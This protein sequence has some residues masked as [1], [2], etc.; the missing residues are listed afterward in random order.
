VENRIQAA[1]DFDRA[2]IK[3]FWRKL[4]NWITGRSNDLLPFDEVRDKLPL[5]GQ[6]YIGLEQVPVESIV[7][8]LGR[9]RDFD[10][11]FLPRQSKTRE[12]WMSIDMAHY[13]Q[14]ILPPVELYKIGDVYFVKDGNHRVS[15]ARERGQLYMDAYIT[16]IDIPVSL[17]PDITVDELAIKSEYAEFLDKTKLDVL[18]PGANL[19]SRITGQG[20]RLL[21]HIDVHRWYLG[22]NSRREIPYSDAVTSWYDD[23]YTP[24]VDVFREQGLA[25]SFSKYS[26][27]DLYLW[28]M[29]YQAYL[30]EAYREEVSGEELPAVELDDIVREEAGV[31]FAEENPELPVRKLIRA[32]EKATWLDEM[33]LKQ[34]RAAFFKRTNLAQLRPQAQIESS[35][36]GQFSRLLEQ[37]KVHH[38]YLGVQH[39]REVTYEETVVSWYD[40]VYMPL[41]R[42]IQKQGVLKEFPGRTE[43]DLFMWIIT[44]QW[45]LRQVSGQKGQS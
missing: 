31:K 30:R 44:R 4:R 1:Q 45:Y 14:V 39:K 21:E 5:R 38:W 3:G 8:S 15:V 19:E 37:I 12:R 41:V 13:G 34:E 36:P 6:H 20:E 16:E 27:S 28:V 40:Q 32:F 11:A 43:A 25:Q 24:I 42:M 23:V 9:F 22:E 26:E 29:E 10:R 17:S 7:G 18:R 33:L 2:L 35:V